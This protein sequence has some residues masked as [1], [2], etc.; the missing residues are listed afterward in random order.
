MQTLSYVSV[1]VLRPAQGSH[2]L[3]LG[4]RAEGRYLGGTWQLIT[5]SIEP[6][7]TAWQAALR[8]VR[9][10]TGLALK[11]LY[12]L[13]QVAQF[14][15]SDV[16]ALCI[17]PMF[18]GFVAAGAEATLDPEHTHLEWIALEQA[19]ARLMW[20]SDRTALE[21]VQSLVLNDPRS[22]EAL[23]IPI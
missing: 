21:Q 22:R 4:R 1:L 5:G 9:E 11:S 16:D 23:A 6:A 12:R 8:E 13:P 15:R 17:V 2:E 14:Y 3:L 19:P 18:A 7:E 10:E 20:P